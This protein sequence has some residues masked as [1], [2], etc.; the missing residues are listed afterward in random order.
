[1]L[2]I[3]PKE[4]THIEV[5]IFDTAENVLETKYSDFFYKKLKPVRITLILKKFLSGFIIFYYYGKKG[6]HPIFFPR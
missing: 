5:G 6:F 2:T 4:A 1:M 3:L